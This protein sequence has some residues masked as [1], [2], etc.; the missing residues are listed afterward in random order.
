VQIS[1]KKPLA[2]ITMSSGE[3]GREEKGKKRKKG[4]RRK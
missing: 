2:D 4:R 3:I 1:L